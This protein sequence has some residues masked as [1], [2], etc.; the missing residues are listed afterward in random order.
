MAER[1]GRTRKG[2]EAKTAIFNMRID[3]KLRLLLEEFAA[4]NG[5][6]MTAEAV[7]RLAASFAGSE[8]HQLDAAVRE[9]IVHA[10]KSCGRSPQD[11][12]N[13]RLRLSL[14]EDDAVAS[15]ETR[16]F[17]RIAATAIELLEARTGEPWLRERSSVAAARSAIDSII[18]RLAG[19]QDLELPGIEAPGGRR[20]VGA[21]NQVAAKERQTFIA[22]HPEL[23]S[24]YQAG[25]ELEARGQFAE[26]SQYVTDE[27]WSEWEALCT[28]GHKAQG[29]ELSA[30][31][32][33]VGAAAAAIAMFD[34][35]AC[36]SN[37]AHG[38]VVATAG[39]WLA[40]KV[41]EE[42]VVK[43]GAVAADETPRWRRNV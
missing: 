1:R 4:A 21:L 7:H 36:A 19:S 22:E 6:S 43:F 13:L 3:I 5:R 15:L 23:I 42:R 26:R 9:G 18:T 34:P 31:D 37:D 11:E 16:R 35:A 38:E 20:S 39:R 24:Y 14:R 32:L 40:S 17:L 10:A 25:C 12:M 2:E 28:E 8:I 33:G 30:Q 29:A 41:V 27:V